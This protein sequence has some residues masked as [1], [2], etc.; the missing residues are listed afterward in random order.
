MNRYGNSRLCSWYYCKNLDSISTPY[1]HELLYKIYQHPKFHKLRIL[2]RFDVLQWLHKDV[3]FLELD[4][5]KNNKVKEDAWGFSIMSGFKNLHIEKQ[6]TTKFGEYLAEDIYVL[7]NKN[8]NPRP[9]KY[10]NFQIDGETNSEILEVKIGTY[11]TPGTA[12]EKILGTPYKYC[13]LPN[14]FQK[15]LKIICIGQIEQYGHSQQLFQDCY[16]DNH[17][18]PFHDLYKKLNIKYVRFTELL[19]KFYIRN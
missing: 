1:Y 2:N 13:E 14:H 19:H 12:C 10:K 9:K 6:W 11:F 15:P 5:K 16:I 7:L 3:S 8:Y 18:K 4:N 17:R